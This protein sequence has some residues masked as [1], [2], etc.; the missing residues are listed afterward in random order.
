MRTIIIQ[1]LEKTLWESFGSEF[2]GRTKSRQDS[3]IRSAHECELNDILDAIVKIDADLENTD[4][5]V[6]FVAYDLGRL[7][8][9]APE[10]LDLSSVV[11]R[12]N[13]ME[14][15]FKSLDAKVAKNADNVDLLMDVSLQSTGYAAAARKHVPHA[16]NTPPDS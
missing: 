16:L 5:P 10:E 15:K 2:L 3:H 6:H 11:M 8:R 9:V 7:P 12:L 14:S 13:Y 4:E 1:A